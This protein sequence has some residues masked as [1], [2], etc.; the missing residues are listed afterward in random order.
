MIDDDDNMSDPWVRV[1]L[2]IILN[3]RLA[4]QALNVRR[5]RLIWCIGEFIYVIIIGVNITIISIDP[6]KHRSDI[7]K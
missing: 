6:S 7:N 3:P 1:S 5:I 4:S 2:T